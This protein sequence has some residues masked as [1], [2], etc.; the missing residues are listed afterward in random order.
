MDV[1]SIRECA[2]FRAQSRLPVLSYFNKK[3]HNALV[4]RV[5]PSLL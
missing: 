2:S 1:V 5:S 4:R 3:R